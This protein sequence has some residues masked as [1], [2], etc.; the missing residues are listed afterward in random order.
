MENDYLSAAIHDDVIKWKHFPRYWPFM[1]EIHWSPGDSPHKDQWRRALMF[2]LICVWINAWVNNRE[3]GDFRRHR[4]HYGVIVMCR[5][6]YQSLFWN[7]NIQTRTMNESSNLCLSRS[8]M[9]IKWWIIILIYIFFNVLWF[10]LLILASPAPKSPAF[11]LCP[12]IALFAL[13]VSNPDQPELPMDQHTKIKAFSRMNT[14]EFSQNCLVMLYWYWF[15][16]EEV[17]TK[18]G[19]RIYVLLAL[20]YSM[21][22][23]SG[24][25]ESDTNLSMNYC[26]FSWLRMVMKITDA[27]NTRV[28]KLYSTL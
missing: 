19:S 27:N 5:H 15:G 8:Y 6:G 14:F 22:R 1:R 24:I 16:F 11:S 10:A 23:K 3:A 13:S 21:D 4:A 17:M 18:F 25:V 2:S 9:F 7:R 28:L 12:Y 26:G 20:I